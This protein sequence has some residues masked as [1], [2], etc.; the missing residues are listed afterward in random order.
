MGSQDQEGKN[1]PQKYLKNSFLK[2]W[3]FF[4]EGSM[5]LQ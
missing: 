4:F 2:S 5:L 3:M 1:D